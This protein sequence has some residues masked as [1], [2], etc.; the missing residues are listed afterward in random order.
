MDVAS[1]LESMD[2]CMASPSESLDVP[3][4]QY[5]EDLVLHY[6]EHMSWY[7]LGFIDTEDFMPKTVDD[8]YNSNLYYMSWFYKGVLPSDTFELQYEEWLSEQVLEALINEQI[9]GLI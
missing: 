5:L 6:V 2:S 9:Y 4:E 3:Y 7:E 8:V 1:S